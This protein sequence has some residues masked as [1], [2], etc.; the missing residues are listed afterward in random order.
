MVKGVGALGGGMVKL[1]KG[2]RVPATRTDARLDAELLRVRPWGTVLVEL[3]VVLVTM[4]LRE[5][6]CSG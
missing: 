1:L 2:W 5:E 3:G 4:V 6:A